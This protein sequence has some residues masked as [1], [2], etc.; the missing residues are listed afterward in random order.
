MMVYITETNICMNILYVRSYMNVLPKS[1]H[2]SESKS[3]MLITEPTKHLD[4]KLKQCSAQKSKLLIRYDKMI[5]KGSF[6][7]VYLGQYKGN[8]VA[9]KTI[10][11]DCLDNK[12]TK[13][14]QRELQVIRVLHANPHQNIVTYHKTM[15][16][17]SRII[18]V[19]EMCS[20]GELSKYIKNRTKFNITDIQSFFSQIISGYK[21]LLK[22]NIVHRDIK[23]ANILLSADQKIIKFIDFGLSKILS[24]DLN[25]TICGSP[26]Y[27]APE[28]LNHQKY[29]SKSD[30]W[31]IG[32]LL[33]EMIY[34]VTP[35]HHCKAILTLRQTIQENSIKCPD[36]LS[37]G[38]VVPGYLIT[39]I[40]RLLDPDPVRRITLKELDA[41]TWASLSESIINNNLPDNQTN[42][43][44]SDNHSPS[45]SGTSYP[46]YPSYPNYS[47]NH[48]SNHLPNYSPSYSSSYP[49]TNGSKKNHPC[50]SALSIPPIS[51]N[52]EHLT[53]PSLPIPIPGPKNK[54]ISFDYDPYQSST[55]DDVIFYP[56]A[57]SPLSN[58][59]S[60]RLCGSE[61]SV[62]D[63]CPAPVPASDK[64]KK[65][66]VIQQLPHKKSLLG[67]IM[68][69][70][71]SKI[72]SMIFG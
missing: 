62:D 23:S 64:S 8:D 9:I 26:L 71:S 65:N 67:S 45:F 11:T 54:N 69:R 38:S 44:L 50:N 13:Q 22:H 14:L 43:H 21:H 12:I 28:L 32:V 55:N 34:G 39:L 53:N 7:E 3:H 37:D 16:T 20:G 27:M 6:S 56:V 1:I 2:S 68:G 52:A 70:K 10:S 51:L 24:S 58:P 41:L 47:P 25:Q 66:Q 33:Y 19:M 35:F 15:N 5:G 31:S 57:S 49:E 36:V 63:I 59:L 42:D 61:I 30:I 17:G 29:D 18:I 40:H 4:D 60:D 46:S 72:R 48:S